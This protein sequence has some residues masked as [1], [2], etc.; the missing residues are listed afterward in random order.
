LI[1]FCVDIIECWKLCYYKISPTHFRLLDCNFPT[2]DSYRTNGRTDKH[3]DRQPSHKAAPLLPP[4]TSFNSS[5]KTTC[6]Q[7]VH[8]HVRQLSHERTDRQ[9][10]TMR[11]AIYAPRNNREAPRVHYYSLAATN[12]AR[13]RT[14]STTI[15][16]RICTEA[17]LC[18]KAPSPKPGLH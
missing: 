18:S 13:P 17:R 9:T 15:V 1:S 2:F 4:P 11:R 10:N 12:N 5:Y 14:G 8:C 6:R 7:I 16:A 3:T